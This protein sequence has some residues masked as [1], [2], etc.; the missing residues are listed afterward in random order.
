MT[1]PMPFETYRAI[2]AVNW[3]LLKHMG[4]SPKHYAHAKENQRED[5]T[6]L[7]LGRAVHTAV[8]EPDEVPLRYAFYEGATRRGK[9]W[10][11]FKTANDDKDILKAEEY[12]LC[13]AVRDAVRGNAAAANLLTGESEVVRTWT[14]AATG[15]ECKARLDH[16]TEGALIDLKTTGTTDAYQF[17]GTA[18]RM[19]YHAQLAFYRRAVGDARP[20]YIIAVEIGPPHDVAVFEL[21]EVALGIGDRKVSEYLYRLHECRENDTWPGR[22]QGIRELSLPAWMEN[23]AA[24][25]GGWDL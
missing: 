9:D 17:E 13:L 20:V 24:I 7:L 2:D 21:T 3:S 25:G 1:T 16:V 19:M 4:D 6:R 5:T 10:D 14:D 8:L 18:A 23:E 22:Y 12:R 11:E 15:I